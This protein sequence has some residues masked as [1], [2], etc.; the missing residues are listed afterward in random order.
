[1]VE[2]NLEIMFFIILY[3]KMSV[4]LGEHGKACAKPLAQYFVGYGKVA[5]LWHE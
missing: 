2:R 3:F 4:V 5:L 1:M